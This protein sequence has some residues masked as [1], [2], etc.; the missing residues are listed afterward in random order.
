MSNDSFF[1]SNENLLLLKKS[2]S[3]DFPFYEMKSSCSQC[4]VRSEKE[5]KKW[6]FAGRR[7]CEFRKLL[8]S[9]QMPWLDVP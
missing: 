6:A 8:L 5:R 9:I 7:I 4:A 1:R 3:S 2:L